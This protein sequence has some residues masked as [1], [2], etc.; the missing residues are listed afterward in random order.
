MPPNPAP[1]DGERGDSMLP[2]T[3]LFRPATKLT[4]EMKQ[5]GVNR[6]RKMGAMLPP[7]ANP[8][9]TQEE[10]RSLN[11]DGNVRRDNLSP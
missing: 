3:A 4:W 2:Y 9:V 5:V 10:W 1:S 8:Q 7:S 11:S 6:S